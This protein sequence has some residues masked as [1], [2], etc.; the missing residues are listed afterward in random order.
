MVEKIYDLATDIAKLMGFARL[1][2]KE[3][4]SNMI[5]NVVIFGINYSKSNPDISVKI[6]VK[7]IYDLATDIASVYSFAKISD[8]K[9]MRNMIL[10]IVILGI[11][12]SKSNPDI[13][14]ELEKLAE[15]S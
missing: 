8:R 4:I 6:M 10:N 9:K 14:K 15:S 5:L 2:D 1:S 13:S 3:K 7:K 11:N 12:Y